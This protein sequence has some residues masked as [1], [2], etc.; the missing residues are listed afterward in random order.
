MEVVLAHGA[1]SI[2]IEYVVGLS[3]EGVLDDVTAPADAARSTAE[4]FLDVLLADEDLLRAEFDAIV[5][6][7]WP[8][9]PPAEPRRRDPADRLP[10]RHRTRARAARLATRPRHPGVGAW[11]RERS[12]PA[13]GDNRGPRETKRLVRG[14]TDEGR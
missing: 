13:C 4:Q 2:V 14:R 6:A 12:P 9:P 8:S 7:E 11:A 10:R 1:N 5:A 3:T